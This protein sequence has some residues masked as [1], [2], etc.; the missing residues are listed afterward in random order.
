MESFL[1]YVWKNRLFREANLKTVDNQE[2]K[3]IHPGFFHQDAGPDFK[4]AVVRIGEITWV[5][6]VEIHLRSSDW[7]RHHH[8]RDGKYGSIILH[9]VYENDGVVSRNE[10]EDY[11]TLE[12]KNYIPTEVLE[13][14]R[15]L[16]FST[17][18]LPC[19]YFLSDFDEKA[20]SAWI[21]AL[22]V[23]RLCRRQSEI[24]HSLHHLDDDWEELFFRML[25]Q[26]FGCKTNAP[27]FEM[28]AQTLPY[29]IVRRHSTSRLQIYSLLFGQAGMLEDESVENDEYYRALQNEYSYLKYKYGLSAIPC[30]L[31]N[32]LRLRPSNFPC[33]R[34]AQFSELLFR[35]PQLFQKLV[36]QPETVSVDLLRGAEPHEYW[37]TH[38]FFGKNCR[39]HSAQLGTK[40]AELVFINTLVPVLFAYGN[41]MARE[42]LTEKASNILEGVPF[43]ENHITRFY[44]EKGFPARNALDSQAILELHRFYC[45]EKKCPLCRIGGTILGKSLSHLS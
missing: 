10:V 16:K 4:Q 7:F 18:R 25:A 12:L 14:Y 31:W 34:L 27:A 43:E 17:H 11:P 32:L 24:M 45:Q 1:H 23:E 41:F 37:R 3:V 21:A 28:L 19:G 36:Q 6:D 44:R 9:V 35:E 22:A 5:G 29:K 30:K 38:Y 8:E 20:F 13:E 42:D 26:N 2:I 39:M 33:L 15:K 40:T